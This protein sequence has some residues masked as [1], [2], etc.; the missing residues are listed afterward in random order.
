MLLGSGACND[1]KPPRKRLPYQTL[2]GTKS[3]AVISLLES[4]CRG[5]VT[6]DA[7]ERTEWVTCELPNKAHYSIAFDHRDRIK[8]ISINAEES[9]AFEM[10]DRVVAPVV[11]ADIRDVMRRS[12]AEP[13]RFEFSKPGGLVFAFA[14]S[15]RRGEGWKT[16]DG[17]C[18]IM[19]HLEDYGAGDWAAE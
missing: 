15:W 1:P 11:P 16:I 10:F 17:W 9:E 7:V 18:S 5:R 12:I 14:P 6:H 3:D 13:D 8:S 19:W 2:L 4:R